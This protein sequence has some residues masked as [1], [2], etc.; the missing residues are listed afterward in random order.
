MERSIELFD[1]TEVAEDEVRLE[2]EWPEDI[3]D[4]L[5]DDVTL[6]L[7]GDAFPQQQQRLGDGTR[8]HGLVH[9]AFD[10]RWIDKHAKLT[11]EATAA[12]QTLVLWKDRE[13]GD[14]GNAPQLDHDLTELI[15]PPAD[16]EATGSLEVTGSMPDADLEPRPA[17]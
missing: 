5:P 14:L 12:S 10:L 17:C 1:V 6:R 8:E 9:V 11:L 7:H 16:D 13:V 2:L 3:V 4:A 15:Q